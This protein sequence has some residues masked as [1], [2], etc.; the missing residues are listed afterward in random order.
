MAPADRAIWGW[1]GDASCLKAASLDGSRAGPNKGPEEVQ[2][3]S[4]VIA[5]GDPTM[6]SGSGGFNID[7]ST[8]LVRV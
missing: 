5:C 8:P 6:R 7:P 4:S 1:R 2:A 3:M